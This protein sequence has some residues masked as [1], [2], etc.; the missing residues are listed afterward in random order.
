[1]YREKANKKFI[2]YKD[3]TIIKN[4]DTILR[5]KKLNIPPAWK[6]VI[7]N[8]NPNAK[9]QAT[10]LDKSGKKQYIY[11]EKWQKKREKEKFERLYF[12]TK[13]LPKIK[14]K[15]NRDFAGDDLKLKKNCYYV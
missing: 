9:V 12:F 1:M 2:Y 6:E 15:I 7:I 14:S 11:H 4:K 8:M 13:N 10:G 3:N 5:I